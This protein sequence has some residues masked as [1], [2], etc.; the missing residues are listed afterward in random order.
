MSFDHE[1]PDLS[2][3]VEYVVTVTDGGSPVALSSST[4]LRLVVS[5]VDDN[6]PVFAASHYEFE[7]PENQSPGFHV[8]AVVAVD[9]DGPPFNRVAYRLSDD[10][11]G[12][13]HVDS[14]SGV[15]VTTT[16]L[17]REQVGHHLRRK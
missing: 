2:A 12:M 13:F 15:I 10:A 14:G 11:L 4:S 16:Q 9:S 1:S 3:A 8:G 6:A 5:D 7:V 17:D